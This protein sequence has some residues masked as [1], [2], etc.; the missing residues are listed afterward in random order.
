M[1]SIKLTSGRYPLPTPY[2]A[3]W[4]IDRQII[5]MIKEATEAEAADPNRVAESTC[6]VKPAAKPSVKPTPATNPYLAARAKVLSEMTD[7]EKLLIEKMENGTIPKDSR[8]DTFVG[9]VA[10]LGDQLSA[11]NN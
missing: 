7:K 1:E 3:N 9:Q 5:E 10:R 8:Y 6:S 4:T 11:A 2:P